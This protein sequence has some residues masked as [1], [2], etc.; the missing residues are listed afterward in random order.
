MRRWLRAAA[1]ETL[2]LHAL[3]SCTALT[4]RFTLMR[5]ARSFWICAWSTESTASW[6]VSGCREQ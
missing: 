3:A 6:E 4:H 2:G 1:V 5:S